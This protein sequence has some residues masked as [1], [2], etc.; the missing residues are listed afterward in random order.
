M[1]L[2]E[3][4]TG[5]ILEVIGMSDLTWRTV[6][7]HRKKLN[8]LQK[9]LRALSHDFAHRTASAD[10]FSDAYFAYN[11]PMNLAKIRIVVLQLQ[12]L[13]PQVLEHLTEFRICDIGCGEG[14]GMLGIYYGLQEFRKL[15][16]SGFDTSPQMLRKC[17]DMMR[18]LKN[19][20]ARVQVR[21]QQQNMSHGLLKKKVAKYDIVILANSLT[22]MFTDGTIPV[23]FIERLLKSCTDNGVII[24][25]EPATKNLSRRLMTLRNDIINR[26]KGQVLLPCLHSENCPLID[27]R[28]QKD[29]CHQ[30][31]LW[32]PPDYMNILNQGLNREIDRLKFSYLVIAQKNFPRHDF[33]AFLVISNLLKEKG[34]KRCFLCTPTGR[35]ELVR[36]NKLECPTNSAFDKILKGDIISFKN[37]LQTKPQHWYITEDT[38][39]RILVSRNI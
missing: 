11:F 39:I 10:K 18:W 3:N 28:K 31:I 6:R 26:Q 33:N 27:I 15:R 5:K 25:L 22:E 17:K 29:W 21:L 30:S 2:P 32:D 34:K 23:N 38:Q 1:R 37:I 13:Y 35:V 36:L 20:D 12:H 24:V 16:F 14:A 4:I 8:R 9:N 19:G 7:L